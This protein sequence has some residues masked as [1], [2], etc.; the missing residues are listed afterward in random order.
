MSGR[1]HV[2]ARMLDSIAQTDSTFTRQG[3]SWVGKCLICGGPLRF[4]AATGEGA[5]VEHIV[6]RGLGG[7]HDPRNLGVTHCRC[8]SEKGRNWDG[9][10]RRRRDPDRYQTMVGRLLAERARRWREPERAGNS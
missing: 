7:S 5:D 3:D 8:N 9:G 6:P 4:D 10:R 1:A 2:S